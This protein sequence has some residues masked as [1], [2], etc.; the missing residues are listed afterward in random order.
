MNI[1]NFN[2][3]DGNF[4]VVKIDDF[5]SKEDWNTIFNSIN[6]HQS[7][8]Q[9]LGEST[10]S[11]LTLKNIV[12][13]NLESLQNICNSLFSP[14][15]DKLPEIAKILDVEEPIENKITFNFLHGTNGHCSLAHSDDY[16]N[17]LKITLLYYFHS[18]PKAFSGGDLQFYHSLDSTEII[19]EIQYENNTIIAFP[20][21]KVHAV[22]EVLN[23]NNIFKDG[24]FVGVTFLK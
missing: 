23:S 9:L 3:N 4:N 7:F 11:I 20:S 19:G 12:D 5:L 10:S 22:T 1:L 6:S 18:F 2:D 13:P 17:G 14:I 15:V 8:F 16:G 21:N 24:R